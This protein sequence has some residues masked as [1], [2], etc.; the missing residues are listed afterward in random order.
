[1][2]VGDMGAEVHMRAVPRYEERLSASTCFLMKPMAASES[3]STS[4][5]SIARFVCGARY[6]KA[7]RWHTSDAEKDEENQ[8]A[9]IEM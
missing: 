8:R 2:F 1:M 3:M 4:S 7:H 6:P 9:S 5:V